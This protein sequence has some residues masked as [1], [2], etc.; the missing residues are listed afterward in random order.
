MTVHP[1]G[2]CAMGDDAGTGVTDHKCRVFDTTPGRSGDAVHEGLYVCDGSSLPCPVGVHPLLTITAV[3]E[4]SM[5][6][7]ARDRG[8]VLDV[9][10]PTPVMEASASPPAVAAQRRRW[11]GR[12]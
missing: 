6:L 10:A 7:F 2:G 5:A 4:R 12:G 11:F 3:A 8:L 9:T 1:L